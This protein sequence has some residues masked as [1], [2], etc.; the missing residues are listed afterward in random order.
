MKNF[1]EPQNHEQ[2]LLPRRLKSGDTIGLFA[3]SGPILDEDRFNKG[4]RIIKDLGFRTKFFRDFNRR[5]NY[6]AGS[7]QRRLEEFNAFL[8]DPEVKALYAIRGGYGAFRLLPLLELELLKKFPKIIIGFSEISVLLSAVFSINMVSF[9]GPVVTSLGTTSPRWL[10]QLF[11]MLTSEIPEGIKPDSMEILV[12]KTA[13]G[14]IVGGNL[15][16]LCHL[17][18]TP[19]ESS[20]KN[21]IVFLEDI[22]ESPYR[23][24]RMLTQLSLSGRL[25]NIAGLILGTFEQCGN[26]E[27]IWERAL[28]VTA[29]L[30]I[31]VWGDF[32]IGHGSRNCTVP[33]GVSA[34]MDSSSGIL[35]FLEPCVC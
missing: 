4:I 12:S 26:Y 14:Q 29:D 25:E 10:R 23:I 11:G 19:Y 5:Q 35:R 13:K 3:P 18:G 34:E 28:E 30:D 7:E 6:L 24:D 20:W 16:S 22:N 31:P 32:P 33:L 1:P 17:I 27:L 8:K 21:C 15:T 9:H 2:F